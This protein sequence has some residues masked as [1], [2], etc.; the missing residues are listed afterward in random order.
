MNQ[1]KLLA[2]L[3]KGDCADD[4]AALLV[5]AYIERF[6]DLPVNDTTIASGMLMFAGRRVTQERAEHLMA[7]LEERGMVED[8][9]NPALDNKES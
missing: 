8:F 2:T 4:D 9:D 5:A 1:L 6:T 7:I 3:R